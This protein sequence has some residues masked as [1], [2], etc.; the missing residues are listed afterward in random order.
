[1]KNL[2]YLSIVAIMLLV[3]NSF[4]QSYQEAVAKLNQH[5]ENSTKLHVVVEVNAYLNPSVSQPFF[6]QHAEIKKS[7]GKIFYKMGKTEGVVNDQ[8]VV[9]VDHENKRIV[10]QNK[11]DNQQE[12]IFQD[13]KMNPDSIMKNYESIELVE[14]KNGIHHY[15]IKN[16]KEL[17]KQVDVFMDGN[18]FLKKMIYTYNK[19]LSGEESIVHL[20]FRKMTTTP[21]FGSSTFR[22]SQYMVKAA[23]GF[24]AADRFKNYHFVFSAD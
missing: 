14:T 7:D 16:S 4:A 24:M 22:E 21:N 3:Q 11:P 9:W 1:M 17:I 23:Q 12:D 15:R 10:G 8:Y 2:R 20:D 18:S 6:T 13:L 5:L 19:E